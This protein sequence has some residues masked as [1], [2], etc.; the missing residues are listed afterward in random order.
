MEVLPNEILIAIL[1]DVRLVE[2][3]KRQ[4][5]GGV[6]GGGGEQQRRRQVVK[7]VHRQW[8]PVPF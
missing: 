4:S 8:F 5:E 1:R 7:A 6:G 3:G 2:K